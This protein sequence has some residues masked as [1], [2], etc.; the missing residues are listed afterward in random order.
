MLNRTCAWLICFN[1]DRSMG[2]QYGKTLIIDNLDYTGNWSDAWWNSTPY[3]M[4]GF[5]SHLSG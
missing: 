2:S 1:L 4:C 5:D 3:N